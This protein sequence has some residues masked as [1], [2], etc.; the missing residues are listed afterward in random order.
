[1]LYHLH[2]RNL[3]V[4]DEIEIELSKGMTVL[5][6]ETGAGKSILVDG[7]SLAL[8]SRADSSFVRQGEK[9]AEVSASFFIKNM[10]MVND[11]LKEN[12]LDDNEDCTLRRTIS[13]EGR[14]RGYINGN[15]VQ[16]STLKELGELIVDI[17]GQQAHQ[18]LIK[19]ENQRQVLDSYSENDTLLKKIASAYDNWRQTEKKYIEFKSIKTNQDDRLELL[20]FQVQELEG[21]APKKGE[22][23]ELEKLHRLSASSSKLTSGLNEVLQLLFEKDNI[24]ALHVVGK[25][26]S[27]LENLSELDKKLKPVI[28]MLTEA[29]VQITEASN[30]LHK[31]AN[32]YNNDPKELTEIENRLSA[33]HDI[34]R[35]HKVEENELHELLIKLRKELEQIEN[36]DS[37][38]EGLK[39]AAEESKTLLEK[40]CRK[41]SHSR[42]KASKSLAS[43]VSDHLKE[44]GMPDGQFKINIINLNQPTSSGSEKIEFEV[45]INPGISPGPLNKVA[46]GGELSRVSLAIQVASNLR[47]NTPILIFDEV[48]AGVGGKTADIVGEKLRDLANE[49][50]VLC[51]THLPQVASK[52]HHHL[53]VNKLSNESSTSTRITNLNQN[54]RI[55]EIARMLGGKKITPRTL[56]HAAEM[57]GTK[58]QKKSVA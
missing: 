43:K 23:E 10:S 31:F 19:P 47:R 11:W 27:I 44:L 29:N 9:K 45:S 46:S 53:K 38:L 49:N 40:E 34:A 37:A 3:A 8:G 42:Q 16:I 26:N 39:I 22:L 18:S 14:S 7:L 57:L 28:N 52:G 6:G 2:I 20:S 36:S 35:K 24:N 5:T 55:K 21:L 56:E 48:D 30:E 50:Q 58:N 12:D 54:D 17:C 51:V 32:S 13:S 33:F 25:A 41:L 4:V 15:S 1:M